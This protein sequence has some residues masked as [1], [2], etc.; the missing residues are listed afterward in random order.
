MIRNRAEA[1]GTRPV[2]AGLEA[3]LESA[4]RL[5]QFQSLP[6]DRKRFVARY[7]AEDTEDLTA[8]PVALATA[9]LSHLE[10]ARVRVPQTAKLR[11]F[12]PTLERDGWVSEHTII[13]TVNDDMPF[14][15]DSL[16]MTLTSLGHAI[17]V[18]IHP[19]FQ[20]ERSTKGELVV[21]HDG[22]S[23]DGRIK[24]ES[25]IHLEIVRETD[26]ALLARIEEALHHALRDVRT[27]VDDW[28]PMLEKLRAA[29]EQ[30]RAT[31]GL[32]EELKTESCAFLEWMARDHFTLLCYREY[33][34]TADDELTARPGTGLGLLRNEP[35]NGASVRLAGRARDEAL[36]PNPLV[37]TKS[38]E[39][40]TVHRPAPFD[41]IGVKVFDAAGRPRMERR[42]LGLFTSAAYNESPRAIPLLRLKARQLME[43]SV[44]DPRS[45]RGKS[46]QH[47]LDTLP[48]DDLFQAS[49]A[50]L[51]AIATGVLGLQERHKLKLFCRRE[52][53][54]RFYSCLVYLPRDQYNSRARRTIESLLLAGLGGNAVT[55]ELTITESAL[56]RLAVTV[57]TAPGARS[58]PDVDALQRELE[59]AVRSWQDRLRDALL[60]ELPEDRAL[61]LLHRFGERFSAAYQEEAD[62]ARGVHDIQKVALI[63]EGG[64]DLEIALV[65]SQANRPERLRL[66]TFKRDESIPLY[67]ALPMLENLGFKVVSERVYSIQSR[68]SPVWIQDF[69]IETA[70]REPVDPAAIGPRFE[71]CFELVLRGEAENDSFNS[72]VV[73]AGLTWREAVLL[74]A[75]CKFLLQTRMRYSQSYIQGVLARYPV[76]CRALVDKFVSL[77]DVDAPE[78][79]RASARADSE[80]RLK[81][82]LDRAVSL[83][84]D[85]ILRAFGAVENAILRTNYFRRRRRTATARS[86]TS[87]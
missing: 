12:N 59:N 77:F 43:Q 48:R 28:P 67:V 9:A 26:P 18:T 86:R 60:A 85:R 84:D 1:K 35:R 53:F 79:T 23:G 50:D 11:V 30:L 76:Y 46:L 39:R 41:H 24:P 2:D 63:H 52:P 21:V 73:T 20:V 55:S 54:G 25:F 27:A 61:E 8:D 83:D 32:D 74:R 65:R 78:E 33:E 49:L 51:R 57:R 3:V 7:Y 64:S 70:G 75:F 68:G 22:K 10:W 58:E 80:R 62:A 82:E 13:Q 45:H 81:A 72:F 29:T 31:R 34:L 17:H 40:S 36:S 19:I 16:S 4:E 87:R 44:L 66:T 71:Q 69:D 15:V 42:F 56:A 37:I 14:L 5:S 38:N 6:V 47:I